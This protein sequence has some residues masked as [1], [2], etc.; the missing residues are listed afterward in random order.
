MV[1]RNKVTIST[2]VSRQA[3]NAIEKMVD[4]KTFSNRSN[5]VESSV[6]LMYF[7]LNANTILPAAAQIG[8]KPLPVGETA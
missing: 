7:V 4:S 6:L 8:I 2:S 5:A 3:D 1:R